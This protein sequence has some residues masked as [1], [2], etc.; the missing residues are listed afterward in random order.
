MQL[1]LSKRPSTK[2]GSA[3]ALLR[4][5]IVTGEIPTDVPL[6]EAELVAL[7]GYGRTPVR[8]AL[9]RLAFE[10]FVVWTEQ[11]SP[12]VRAVGLDDLAQITE[13]RIALE[14]PAAKLAARRVTAQDLAALREACAELAGHVLR[15]EIYEA[16]EADFSFHLSIAR[17]SR[18]RY[19][20]DAVRTLNAGALRLWF[21]AQE[22]LGPSEEAHLRI[23][24]ALESRDADLVETI[25]R[26]HATG[27][28]ERQLHVRTQDFDNGRQ[29]KSKA[30]MQP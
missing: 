27:F 8:E 6:N 19:L 17:Y 26:E 1:H 16:T 9:K 28:M 14:V 3:Y 10:S 29:A 2:A 12:Y 5:A 24:E 7:S 20:Y 25:V 23:V 30:E 13:A 21:Q 22:L 4:R 15:D 18:N 11:R